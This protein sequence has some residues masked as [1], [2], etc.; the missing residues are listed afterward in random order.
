MCVF[1]SN[2]PSQFLPFLIF[3]TNPSGQ[4]K[5]VLLSNAMLTPSQ[6]MTVLKDTFMS[7]AYRF[8]LTTGKVADEWL[9]QV[10]NAPWL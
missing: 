10:K 6:L 7:H 1:A 8:M 4:V 2:L 3:S 9:A 5:A